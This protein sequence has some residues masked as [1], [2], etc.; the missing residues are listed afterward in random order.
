MV[1]N[2]MKLVSCSS[3]IVRQLTSMLPTLLEKK[4]SMT[5]FT[6]IRHLTPNLQ[7]QIHIFPFI[8]IILIF[9]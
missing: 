6:K 5:I 2:F 8:L 9:F 7:F 3:S 4:N 1:N